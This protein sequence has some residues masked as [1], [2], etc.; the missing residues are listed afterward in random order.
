MFSLVLLSFFRVVRVGKSGCMMLRQIVSTVDERLLT[1]S[2]LNN[3]F[4]NGLK[5]NYL[6]LNFSCIRQGEKKT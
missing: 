3:L 5:K 2:Q 4:L 1:L 6:I